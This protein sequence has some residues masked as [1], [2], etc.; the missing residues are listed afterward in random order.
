MLKNVCLVYMM[1]KKDLNDNLI[2]YGKGELVST[3]MSTN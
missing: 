3:Q 1:D 2:I